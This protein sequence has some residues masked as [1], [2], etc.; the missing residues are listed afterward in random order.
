MESK[1]PIRI[2]HIQP[3]KYPEEKTIPHTLE[4]LQAQVGGLIET[5]YPWPDRSVCLVCNDEGKLLQ[6]PLNRVVPELDDAIAG[7]FFLCGLCDTEDGGDFCSLSPEDIKEFESRFH[8]PQL[9]RPTPLGIVVRSCTPAQYDR[10]MGHQRTE[11]IVP[12][13]ER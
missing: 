7:N 2:L 1:E 9:F 5:V 13:E 12:G 8:D 4:S 6:L 3:G 10:I 11:P